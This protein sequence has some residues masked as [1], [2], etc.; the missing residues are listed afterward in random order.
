MKGNKM[1]Q[2]LTILELIRFL[3]IIHVP[4]TI[5]YPFLWVH[6]EQP[7]LYVYQ[8]YKYRDPFGVITEYGFCTALGEHI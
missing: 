5:N 7:A 8:E 4:V 2:C 6:S 3:S 1:P